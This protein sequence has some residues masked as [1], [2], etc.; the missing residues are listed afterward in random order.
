[1]PFLAGF[2]TPQDY[3]AT[4]NGTTDDTA[5]VQAAITAVASGGS[6]PTGVLLFP[7]GT[8]KISSALTLGSYIELRGM[9]SGV[10]VINQVTTTVNGTTGI[11]LTNVKITG[12]SI[13]GP[14]SG[15]GIGVNFD[16]SVNNDTTYVIMDDVRVASFGSHGV[17]IKSPETCRFSRINVTSN[18]GDAWHVYGTGT[19]CSWIS[20]YALNN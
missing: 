7:Q 17:Q 15:S 5:A 3:G 18:S 6:N 13:N 19:S 1:M 9:G 12:L 11:D 14:G 4:G 20:C 8:Y 10:S 2:V 16:L